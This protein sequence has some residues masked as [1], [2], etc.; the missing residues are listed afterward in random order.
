MTFNLVATAMGMG[1]PSARAVVE[2][3]GDF[4]GTLGVSKE[5]PLGITDVRYA[6]RS[7]AAPA[8]SNWPT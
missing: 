8:M 2:D 6:S 5:A 3:A 7:T 4:R 1:F